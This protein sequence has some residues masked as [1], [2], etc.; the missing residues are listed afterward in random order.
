MKRRIIAIAREEKISRIGICAKE[1]YYEKE[2]GLDK[3]AS[4]CAKG[5][6]PEWAK[7]IVVCAFS[8][9]SGA[10]KGNISRYAQG[11]DYHIVA[12]EK[13]QKIADFLKEQGYLAECFADTGPLN[14]RLMAQLSGIAFIGKN[15]MA[16]NPQIGSWFFIGYI[17]TDCELEPDGENTDNCAGCRRCIGACPSGALED[18]GF[19]EE[20]C[21][22]YITQKKGPI[23]GEEADAMRKAKTLW[24]CDICQEV[25]P[26]NR[27]VPVCEIDE[28]REN[29][30]VNLFVDENI[31]NKEFRQKYNNKAFAWR[32]KSVLIRNQKILYNEEENQK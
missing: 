10:K 24:G 19:C 6:C 13:M 25:C 18:G 9:F 30:T 16:I 26:H 27:N 14:E 29:L 11:A 5:N 3:K 8:Y 2:K 22:S 15:Q 7:S 1:K 12:K 23:S 32:G 20:K 21:L 28:F 4:F 31:S 17:L